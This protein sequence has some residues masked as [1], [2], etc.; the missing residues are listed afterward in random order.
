VVG[1]VSAIRPQVQWRWL[2]GPRVDTCFFMVP[3]FIGILGYL[4]TQNPAFFQSVLFSVIVTDSFEAGPFHQGPT[5]FAYADKRNREHFF[6][7]KV[8]RRIF[9]WSPPLIMLSSVVLYLTVKE[10]LIL[11]WM[12]WAIQHFIQQNI[13]IL[14]LY[15]NQNQGEAI[16][17]RTIE[18]RSQ[19]ASCLFF[20]GIF[21]SV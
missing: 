15:H 5:W 2:F 7:D 4:C 18:T 10:L 17:N 12:L 9:L 20:F 14:L 8:R 16:V 13:G 1:G 19:W 11:V 6:N 21:G 3:I